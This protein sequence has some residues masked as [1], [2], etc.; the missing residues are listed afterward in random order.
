[1]A[2]L[3]KSIWAKL[4][5]M[6][7]MRC[8]PTGYLAHQA[9]VRTGGK[10]YSGPFCGMTY[11]QDFWFGGYIAK[12][13][14]IYE[15]E[16]HGV[17]ESACAMEPDLVVDVGAAEGYYSVGLCRRLPGAKHVA[18]EIA[19]EGRGML[20]DL[21]RS[22]GCE[23][24]ID[25][26]EACD[27]EKLE[28]ALA[29]AKKPFCVI[30]VE[31]Y[32]KVLVDPGVVPS[33]RRAMMLVELH[34]GRAPGIAER[35]NELFGGTHEIERIWSTDRTPGDYPFQSI[36]FRLMPYKYRLWAVDECRRGKMSWLWMKPKDR[37]S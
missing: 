7:P 14:G 35:L 11:I 29:G 15:R 20:R 10:V 8:R 24:R 37:A 5:R 36:G 18:F 30:D 22:N 19:E 23:G 31:G 27:P 33:L 16:L 12:I 4:R 21:A 17:I 1:M 13:L 2:K 3:G 26:R 9:F 32:E 34:P 28:A 25:I 6:T